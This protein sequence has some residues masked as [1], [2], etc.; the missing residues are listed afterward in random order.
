MSCCSRKKT[1]GKE[2]QSISMLKKKNFLFDFQVYLETQSDP[3]SVK[4]A[5]KRPSNSVE[6]EYLITIKTGDHR[7]SGTDGPVY[8]KIFGR[9]DKQTKEILLTSPFRHD[10]IKQI[11]VKAIDIGKPQRIILRHEDKTN[12]WYID[13]VEISVHNFLIRLFRFHLLEMNKVFF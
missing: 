3:P 9:D 2:P 11:Q 13:Y 7:N 1:D 10:S 8:I 4:I 5:A 6:I 12:G